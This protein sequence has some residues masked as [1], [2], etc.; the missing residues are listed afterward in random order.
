MRI[1]ILSPLTLP[2]GTD[3]AE[4]ISGQPLANKKVHPHPWVANLAYGLGQLG[5]EVHV[6]TLT[7]NITKD[8]SFIHKKV[9]YHL[10]RSTP[11]RFRIFTLNFFDNKKIQRFLNNLKPDIVHGQG[12]QTEGL[13][14]VKSNYPSIITSHGEIANELMSYK[15]NIKYRVKKYFEN[16]VN[17]K[18]R[19]AIGVSPTTTADLKRFLPDSHVFLID[20][21]LD[22]IFFDEYKLEWNPTVFYVGA[23]SQR[24]RVL[25]LIKA[26]EQLKNIKLHIATQTPEDN[27]FYKTIIEYVNTNKLNDKIIFL[28]N[29]A[30]K[31]VAIE[32]SKCLCT[33]LASNFESFGMPLAEAMSIGKPVIGSRVGGIPY[34]IDDNKTGFLIES[35]NV[36]QIK[37]KVN[38]F[39]N[40]IEKTKI[41]GKIAYENA[42]KRW[43][44]V[45]VAKKTI[46]VYK[47]VI[48]EY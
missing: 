8:I 14:A 38:F 20:N 25:E 4:L 23:I 13:S 11:K 36:E 32:Q 41:M 44:P 30:P 1:A 33:V 24:K 6:I 12:R 26:I 7:S 47:K 9:N 46:E 35:G 48:T 29:L 21:A 45:S 2:T 3:F 34:L 22:P 31:Q 19:F 15:K 16:K 27:I 37:E 5:H 17:K 39:N 28:G 18:M 42:F 40:N 43:H 10:L